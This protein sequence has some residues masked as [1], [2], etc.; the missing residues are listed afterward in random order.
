MSAVETTEQSDFRVATALQ[1]LGQMI[2][3]R[4]PT[5][6]LSIRHGDDPVG[7]YLQAEVD[8]D[9]LTDV[10]DI[11]LD[12]RVEMEVGE[13]LPIELVPMLPIHREIANLHRSGSVVERIGDSL[14]RDLP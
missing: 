2:L 12:R 3:S 7:T 8:V 4:Y 10:V 5:A 14:S 1:E 11:V 6:T 9:T 13:G